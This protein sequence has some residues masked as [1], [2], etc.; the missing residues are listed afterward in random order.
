MYLAFDEIITPQTV[1]EVEGEGMPVYEEGVKPS[2]SYKVKVGR[3]DLFVRFNVE[4]PTE[5]GEGQK[6]ELREILEGC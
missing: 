1:R 6:K 2:E 4:F 3:G 5:L